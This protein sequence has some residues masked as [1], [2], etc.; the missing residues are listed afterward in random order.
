VAADWRSQAALKSEPLILFKM[1]LPIDTDRQ[2]LLS[3]DTFEDSHGVIRLIECQDKFPSLQDICLEQ[4]SIQDRDIIPISLRQL[5][6]RKTVI[7][8]RPEGIWYH[9]YIIQYWGPYCD[10]IFNLGRRINTRVMIAD[11]YHRGINISRWRDGSKVGLETYIHRDGH[12]DTAVHVPGYRKDG[13][14]YFTKSHHTRSIIEYFKLWKIY[15]RHKRA[16]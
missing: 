11:C 15:L 6:Q 9:K 4:I 1:D 7:C 16:S 2:T 8:W 10:D 3:L 5:V 12:R 13:F 14:M